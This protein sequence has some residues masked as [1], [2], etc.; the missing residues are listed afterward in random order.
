MKKYIAL[1]QID[2]ESIK[3]NISWKETLVDS[4]KDVLVKIRETDQFRKVGSLRTVSIVS[5]QAVHE[6][7]IK[8][9]FPIEYLRNELAYW[10]DI[11]ISHHKTK[12]VWTIDDL[13]KEADDGETLVIAILSKERCKKIEFSTL[14]VQILPIKSNGLLSSVK[15]FE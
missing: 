11:P 15:V 14:E 1:F 4:V 3:D 5:E 12:D 6:R 8:E 13:L 7:F 2:T 10:M 9:C